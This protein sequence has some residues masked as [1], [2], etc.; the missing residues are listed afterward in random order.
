M[1][2]FLAGKQPF[3]LI[4]LRSEE[5]ANSL[6]PRLFFLPYPPVFSLSH[7]HEEET[8]ATFG[9][10]MLPNAPIEIIHHHTLHRLDMVGHRIIFIRFYSCANEKKKDINY[11]VALRANC[12]TGGIYRQSAPMPFA[13]CALL[14]RSSASLYRH[15]SR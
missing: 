9:F 12:S 5:F 15:P 10:L 1:A 14:C 6:T 2:A 11:R 4:G 13:T 7:P 8:I 3:S